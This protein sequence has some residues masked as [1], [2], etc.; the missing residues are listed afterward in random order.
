MQI[1]NCEVRLMGDLTN[2]IPKNGVTPAEAAILKAIHGED[3]VIRVEITGNDRR[4]HQDEYNRLADIYGNASNTEGEK[5][6]YKMFPKTFDPRL[7]SEFKQVG[8]EVLDNVP[9]PL[10]TPP[11]APD[12]ADKDAEFFDAEAE[13][14]S[15]KKK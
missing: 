8:V 11:D 1:A 6:F 4:P 10:P 2:S 14:A 9:T 15:K 13:M 3:A 12:A 5:I 7:P